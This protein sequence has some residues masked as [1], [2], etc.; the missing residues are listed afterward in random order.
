MENLDKSYTRMKRKSPSDMGMTRENTQVL[1]EEPLSFQEPHLVSIK[2]DLSEIVFNS[3][4]LTSENLNAQL[5]EPD[6]PLQP[7][8]ESSVPKNKP[9]T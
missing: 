4:L 9:V 1:V 3:S 7:V 8:P 2:S 6:S 5:N